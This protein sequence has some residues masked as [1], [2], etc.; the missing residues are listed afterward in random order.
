MLIEQF[1]G[2]REWLAGRRKGIG[3]SDV[4]G[5]LSLSSFRSPLQIWN[6]KVGISELDDREDAPVALRLRLGTKL[7][8]VIAEVLEEEAGVKVERLSFAIASNPEFPGLLCSPD[9][10]VIE[11][12]GTKCLGEF[13][14]ADSSK[15]DEWEEGIPKDYLMQ[16][17]HNLGVTGLP[18][19]Y[20]ACLIG[21]T[22]AF[23][24]IR[25]ERDEAMI[26]SLRNA[27]LAFW[28]MVKNETPPEPTGAAGDAEALQQRFPKQVPGKVL[29]LGPDELDLTWE[30]HK[31][32]DELDALTDRETQI[33][34]LIRA[35]L[36]DAEEGVLPGGEGKWTWKLQSKK[37]FVVKEWEGR[38]LRAPSRPKNK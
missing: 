4:A 16:T 32:K 20:I 9:A 29:S 6:D 10:W 2:R 7:E 26:E 35:K 19:A 1:P 25:V 38:V 30:L 13:K 24:W 12:D 34:N 36:G 21:G 22:R 14:S 15:G 28:E 17:Q 31:I 27:A 23:R 11:P 3:G 18:A 5:I 33:K 37:S 8:P